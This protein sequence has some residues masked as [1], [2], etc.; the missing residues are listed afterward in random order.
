MISTQGWLKWLRE[1]ASAG[2]YD[3]NPKMVSEIGVGNDA[4]AIFKRLAKSKNLVLITKAQFDAKVQA[5]FY[6]SVVV[7]PIL[8]DDLHY[9]LRSVIKQGSPIEANPRLFSPQHQTG[10][11][12]CC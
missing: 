6:H 11:P 2:A 4:V 7:I 5:S 3:S 12:L 9:F 1:H 8:P 10:T